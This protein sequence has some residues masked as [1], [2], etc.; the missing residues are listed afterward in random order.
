[1]KWYSRVTLML[2]MLVLIMS[3]IVG[4]SSSNNH[5]S[6]HSNASAPTE[7]YVL[8]AASLADAMKEL[9]PMYESSH[10]GQKLV[11]SY[12]SSGTLQQQIEQGAPADLFV[13]AASK[14]MKALVGKDLIDA[15]NTM[16]LLKNQLVLIVPQNTETQLKSFEDLQNP[17]VKKV[18]IGHPESV[19]AGTYA[20]ET[21]TNLS[22]WDSL[23]S[24]FVFA[25]DVRQVLSY[26]ETG[27][28]DAGIVYKTDATSSDKVTIAA[29][30]DE[31]S[32]SPIVYP[33]GVTKNSKHPNE[34]QILY[35]WL[36]GSE[37]ASVFAKYGFDPAGNQ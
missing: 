10:P 28:V 4:C 22:V 26:V 20:K 9:T 19:P 13:S 21:L 29:T 12:G 27:N 7:L 36:H 30:A 16:D 34:A 32:H 23:Q 11:I 15:Q 33:M 2:V 5:P 18:A 14:Q 25:K 6:N 8:A 3:S 1:M 35:K 17:A 31:K 24:K 37:A